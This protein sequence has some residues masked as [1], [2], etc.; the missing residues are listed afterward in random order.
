MSGSAHLYGRVLANYGTATWTAGTP[1]LFNGAVFNNASIGTLNL[2]ATGPDY[3]YTS[4]GGMFNNSGTVNRNVAPVV[5]WYVP[6][7]NTG[8]VNLVG[9]VLQLNTTYTQTAGVTNLSNAAIGK[10]GGPIALLGGQLRGTGVIT[11]NLNHQGGVI[12]PGGSAGVLKLVG[13]YVQSP[14]AQLEIEVGG[15]TSG[16]QYDLFDVT[17]S[18][19]I[20]GTLSLS[21]INAFVP[22]LGNTFR[23]MNY[24]SHTGAF[25]TVVG[26]NVGPGLALRPRYYPDNVTLEVWRLLFLPLIVR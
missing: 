9:A 12:A 25:A 19:A 23:V 7:L 6:I 4:S 10:T 5:P 8:N 15:L 17:G 26:S 11:A 3:W 13:D 24:G 22:A 1:I 21:T 20:N 14:G 2:A 18:A 16:T